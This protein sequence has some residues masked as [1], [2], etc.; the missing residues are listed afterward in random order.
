[1]RKKVKF[2]IECEADIGDRV[3]FHNG[4]EMTVTDIITEYSIVTKTVHFK[5]KLDGRYKLDADEI[6]KVIRG[7]NAKTLDGEP[8]LGTTKKG[9]NNGF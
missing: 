9:G 2:K 5:Y 6:T 4:K 3:R 8:N 1:M 7:E